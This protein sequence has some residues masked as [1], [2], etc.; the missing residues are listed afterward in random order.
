[1][2]DDV[3]IRELGGQAFGDERDDEDDRQADHALQLHDRQ[4]P[5]ARRDELHRDRVAHRGEHGD[6]DEREAA[7]GELRLQL[8]LEHDHRDAGEREDEA[9]DG[10][11][12][13]ALAEERPGDH[14]G[15]H[16]DRGD[17]DRRDGGGDVLQTDVFRE[18]VEQRLEEG[19]EQ[20]RAQIGEKRPTAGGRRCGPSCGRRD[21]RLGPIGSGMGSAAAGRRVRQKRVQRHEEA[22]RQRE[23]YPEDRYRSE[24]GQRDLGGDEGYPVEEHGEDEL[25]VGEH[26]RRIM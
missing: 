12:T 9:G 2:R 4:R 13:Y 10:E 11:Q 21:R 19:D 1:M 17:D 18:E 20:D 16:R 15:E 5:V 23:S 25:Q 22:R 7:R 3:D 6:E 14:R 8:S 26:D 24:G